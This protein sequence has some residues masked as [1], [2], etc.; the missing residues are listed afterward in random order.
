MCPQRHFGPVH[1]RRA[2][3]NLPAQSAHDRRGFH[4]VSGRSR[5]R[6]V[7]SLYRAISGAD[8]H[9]LK[10][11]TGGGICSAT[12]IACEA[13]D[14]RQALRTEVLS[15]THRLMLNEL[16]R[17]P[18]SQYYNCSGRRQGGPDRGT[19]RQAFENP[20]RAQLGRACRHP[21][22][23]GGREDWRL[24]SAS[25]EA[26]RPVSGEDDIFQQHRR[27]SA[28]YPEVANAAH[29]ISAGKGRP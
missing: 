9:L 27:I 12:L 28:G 17:L 22:Q 20:L 7:R 13:F 24:V 6:G 5:R 14:R 11:V 18:I 19:N 3:A 16:C 10:P 15:L 25:V 2:G 8:A 1:S 23:G 4:A 29:V 26:F 21:A